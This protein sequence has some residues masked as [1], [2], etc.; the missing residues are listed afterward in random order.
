MIILN[1]TDI[2]LL[3]HRRYY[4][5]HCNILIFPVFTL[6]ICFIQFRNSE[7][8]NYLLDEELDF[9]SIHNHDNNGIVR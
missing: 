7:T 3:V 6:C 9:D 1:F 4:S 8:I 5:F 2:E